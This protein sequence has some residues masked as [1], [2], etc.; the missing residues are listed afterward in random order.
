MGNFHSDSLI[1]IIFIMKYISK[2]MV[3][4]LFSHGLISGISQYKPKQITC[5]GDLYA[6]LQ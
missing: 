1:L 4:S 3:L 2:S 5:Q 6:R